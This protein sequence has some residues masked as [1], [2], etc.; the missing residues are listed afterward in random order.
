MNSS[1]ILSLVGLF[2]LSAVVAVAAIERTVEKTFAVAGAGTLRVE[3]QAGAVRVTTSKENVVKISA[4]QTIR[5]GSER[6]ADELLQKLEL[7]FD[8]SG[9]DLKV[10]SKYEKKPSGWSFG[11]WP[12][13]KVDI[14]VTVPAS[15]A[16]DLR[17]SGG[18]IA[19]G[20]LMG[21]LS[22]RTSGG[23]IKLGKMGNEVDARTSGGNIS[24]EDA[25]GPV[26]LDTSGGNITAG[27][28]AGSARLSTSGGN[29]KVDSAMGSLHANTSGGNIR[30]KIVGALKEDC[31]VTTSG[32]TVKVSVDKMAG[33]KLDASTSGGSVDISGLSVE[34]TSKSRSKLAGN[35]NG[36]GP[37]LKVRSSGGSVE[38][39]A[40]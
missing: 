35:G 27:R 3:T 19:V 16:A 23:S 28:V 34:T 4:R 7:T 24:L 31:S 22:A 36:G 37:L 1:R 13:V 12:P 26:V 9:N 21:K 29:I 33:F 40:N 10:I 15:F 20:D 39:A 8:Q 14:I 38:V 11:S 25:N 2:S 6:E 18:D 30:A 32:G 5:A 17:T